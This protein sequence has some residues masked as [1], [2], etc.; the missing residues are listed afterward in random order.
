MLGDWTLCSPVDWESSIQLTGE[1]IWS[2]KSLPSTRYTARYFKWRSSFPLYEEAIIPILQ[3]KKKKLRLNEVRWLAHGHKTEIPFHH[4]TP[5]LEIGA[6]QHN[7]Q[8]ILSV[9]QK[10]S[11]LPSTHTQ[12]LLAFENPGCALVIPERL[13]PKGCRGWIWIERERT[14]VQPT[15]NPDCP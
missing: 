14:G 13:A 9:E 6:G 1:N 7:M 2:I 15:T 8:T 12:F 11:P 4:T 5:L 3:V 10:R